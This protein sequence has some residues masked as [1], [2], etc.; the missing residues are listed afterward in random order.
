MTNCITDKIKQNVLKISETSM[1]RTFKLNEVVFGPIRNGQNKSI[2][3]AN[4]YSYYCDMCILLNITNSNNN[5]T[6]QSYN[7]RLLGKPT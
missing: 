2:T 3:Q 6:S 5:I 4:K 7:A 1:V